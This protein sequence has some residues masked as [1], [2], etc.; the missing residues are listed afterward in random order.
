MR[1][2]MLNQQHQVREGSAVAPAP[3][4]TPAPL[5]EGGNFADYNAPLRRP[6]PATRLTGLC[7]PAAGGPAT[8]RSAIANS[9]RWPGDG[10]CS[11][12]HDDPFLRGVSQ[13]FM[14]QKTARPG[15]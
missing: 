10:G 7:G 8:P 14:P 11:Y 2:A 1:A 15:C 13:A 6:P 5:G 3:A 4:A 12:R 9:G